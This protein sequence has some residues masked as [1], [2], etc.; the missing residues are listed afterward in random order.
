MSAGDEAHGLLRQNLIALHALTSFLVERGLFTEEQYRER[1]A[2]FQERFDAL[3]EHARSLAYREEEPT[4]P[5]P[6]MVTL[7][8]EIQT[9]LFSRS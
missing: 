8:N 4:A 9:R 5:P 2:W 1:F 6:E 7:I 3:A